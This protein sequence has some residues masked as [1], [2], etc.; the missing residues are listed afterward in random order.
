MP[1]LQE[2]MLRVSA[3]AS[4][5]C[6]NFTEPLPREEI[7]STC[8]FHDMGNVIKFDFTAFPKQFYEPEGPE[9]WQKVKEDYIK[10]YGSNEHVATEIISQEAGLPPASLAFL[11]DIGFSNATKNLLG[12]SFGSMICIYAD[13]RV[14]PYGVISMEERIEEGHTRYQKR[15]H[16]MASDNFDS[17]VES[18][19]KIEAQ[20]FS[21]CKIKPEDIN[22]DTV[23]PVILELRN[24]MVK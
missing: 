24:F 10:K 3:V 13:M 2:H 22:N 18:L 12:G 7:I 17:L 11:Q 19:R 23:K 6:G 4:L 20:I 5:I 21:K 8:L 14:G 15:E 16:S 1:N 9:Y